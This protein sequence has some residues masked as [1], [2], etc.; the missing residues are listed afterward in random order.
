MPYKII[1][2]IASGTFGTV[3][4]VQETTNSEFYALKLI[5]ENYKSPKELKRIKRG[6]ESAQIVSHPN[7]VKMIEWYEEKDQIGFVMEFVD[8][9]ETQN[10]AYS[11]KNNSLVE[12]QNL[13]SLQNKISKIIQIAN[14]LEALHSTG[15]IHRDLKPANILETK[16]GQIKITDFDLVKLD[17]SSTLTASGAFLGTAKYS[18]PEQCQNS[19][20]ID[21]RSDLYSLG[22]LFYQ[23][24]C[25]RV[26][27]EGDS[28]AEIAL[29]HIRTPLISPKQFVPDLPEVL[30]TVIAKL[31]KKNP[32]DRFQS[33]QEVSKILDTFLKEGKVENLETFG[34]FLLTPGFVGR[35]KEFSELSKIFSET[36]NKL[37]TILISG[38]QGVGKTKLWKEF[39]LGL[40]KN[41]TLVFETKCRQNGNTFEPL[42]TIL[43]KALEQIEKLSGKEQAE[44]IGRFGKDLCKI[45]PQLEQKFFFKHLLEIPALEGIESELRLFEAFTN[46]LNNIQKEKQT[47]VFF[48]DDLQ[49]IDELS[50]KFL[51]YLTRSLSNNS[52][53]V[54]GTIRKEQIENVLEEIDDSKILTLEN[55]ELEEV[56]EFLTKM[57]G[58]AD[59][60]NTRFC[61]EILKRTGGNVLF[62]QELIF[63]LL[64]TKE[65]NK[66]EGDWDL[67]EESFTKLKL[68]KSIQSVVGERL[69]FLPKNLLKLL[70]V[71]ALLGKFFTTKVVAE[72]LSLEENEVES[73][74]A[75][76][77]FEGILE[78]SESNIFEF[79]NDSFRESLSNSLKPNTKKSIHRKIAVYLE[80]RF[81][82]FEI[83]EELANHYFEAGVKKKTF[84]YCLKA[85]VS[86]KEVYDYAKAE[87]FISNAITAIEA[88]NISERINISNLKAECLEKLGDF[89]QAEKIYSHNLKLA[90]D[91]NSENEIIA[92]IYFAL[93]RINSELFNIENTQKYFK[94]SLNLYIKLRDFKF[95]ILIHKEL[96]RSFIYQNKFSEAQKYLDLALEVAESNKIYDEVISCY[97]YQCTIL[98][99][100]G[101]FDEV[102]IYAKKINDF[103][104]KQ[105]S[106]RK[107][108][109]GLIFLGWVYKNLTNFVKASFYFEKAVKNLEK[110]SY[111]DTYLR[112]LNGVS[113][114]NFELGNFEKAIEF[115]L[116]TIR[117]A[118]LIKDFRQVGN[119]YND[120]AL[121][122]TTYGNFDEASKMLDKSIEVS[123]KIND[124][125]QIANSFYLLGEIEFFKS[126]FLEAISN[127]E[128]SVKIYSKIEMEFKAPIL[129][130]NLS[131]SN[132][133]LRNYPKALENISKSQELAQ[134]FENENVI[135]NCQILK[136]KIDFMLG[137]KEQAI[138]NIYS[139]IQSENDERKSAIL[140]ISFCNL[141]AKDRSLG[142]LISEDFDFQEFL[143]E[144]KSLT[145]KVLKEKFNYEISK[146]LEELK[147]LEK[148]SIS[149]D[150]DLISSF[151]KWIEPS[152]LFS[153]LLEFLKKQTNATSAILILQ[154]PIT[155]KFEIASSTNEIS[156]E[157]LD[158]SKGIFE[159]SIKNHKPILIENA[160]ENPN[161]S[162]NQSVVG[163]IFLSVLVVPVSLNKKVIGAIY[164]ERSKLE[165]EK[166]RIPDLQQ[167]ERIAKLISPIL[168]KQ[169]ENKVLK[170]ESEV[171]KLGIFIGNSLK[172][173]KLYQ[174]IQNAATVDYTTYIYGETGTGKELV[175]TALHK[176][177]L[178]KDK[179]FVVINCSAIPKDLAESELFGH[180]KGAFSGAISDKTGKFELANEG[181]LF[182]D[183]VAELSLEIQAKL[184]RA[185]QQK[186]IWRVGGN[187]GIKV[188]IKIIVATHKNLSE[189]VQK[190]NF[191]EDLFH[192]LDVLKIEVPPLRERLEDIPLLAN[193]ILEKVSKELNKKFLGFSQSGIKS[194][195]EQ[196]WKGNVRELENVITKS[197]INL[198]I[199]KSLSENDLF[200]NQITKRNSDEPLEVI[201]NGKSFDEKLENLGKKILLTNL[202]STNWNKRQ[203]ARELGISRN[204]LKRLISKYEL[205]E[206]HSSL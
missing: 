119:S 20:K 69:N 151:V 86:L 88:R 2:K 23:L 90:F 195:F 148:P 54:L 138:Q 87:T 113:L 205:V 21:F 174:Q 5:H 10:L 117:Q 201:L 157:D 43:A 19:A 183:E 129:L 204:R 106:S 59:P 156:N 199:E 161:F 139:F 196:R 37:K 55:F 56:R 96:S 68:P 93:G 7:C 142:I 187:K 184:L 145:E 73:K 101:K 38:E 160:L 170:T 98:G 34:D 18:S 150:L 70:E 67:G 188:N 15:I 120:I 32:K 85:G 104:E 66:S 133:K 102:L 177:S 121:F 141:F 60:V 14:G 33:A 13:A 122:Y 175:A 186:E 191:R 163:K 65:L 164:V 80:K 28:L 62:V 159:E 109:T 162:S 29:G 40:P 206:P 166:F 193:S 154:N 135:F 115:S 71:G 4:K 9:V 189:E 63:H 127:Y 132:Y 192:R 45:F 25:G 35:G 53:L 81:N 42:Q 118:I 107:D 137:N 84:N 72:V 94:L 116:K 16:D 41:S 126:N 74:L 77:T 182:L 61:E 50:L 165:L 105:G 48:F 128:E 110:N 130:Y 140:R 100:V 152:N 39:R 198:Q 158:F 176:L 89:E 108:F 123:R 178:R 114:C 180:S 181:T 46:F 47:L 75:N 171:K 169:N 57:F 147:L 64:E 97:T 173:Q 124:E 79:V 190:G 103:E 51:G 76:S 131:K 112:A 1:R 111:S 134:K 58:K 146:D 8:S 36:T 185:I 24:V 155:K 203:S 44:K 194:L 3:Y 144:T 168:Q 179:P 26:P 27:F 172:M 95:I 167:V 49:W 83:L 202:E 197:V 149:L 143:L 125:F 6:F 31:L 22:V 99:S 12:T 78:K 136:N 11:E 52:I 91:S 30:N 92:D 200:P 153:E 82:E 17:D